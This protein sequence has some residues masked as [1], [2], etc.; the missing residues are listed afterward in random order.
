M[1]LGIY[2]I[3][4]LGN[5]PILLGSIIILLQ[6]PMRDRDDNNYCNHVLYYYNKWN[7]WFD[8]CY[9][10][11]MSTF[12]NKDYVGWSCGFKTY[13]LLFVRTN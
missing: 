3:N 10:C 1:K 6:I 2:K 8:Q 9:V 7:S 5:I 13:F 11:L 12:E 4:L